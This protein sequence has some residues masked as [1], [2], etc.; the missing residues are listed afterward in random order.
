M[1]PVFWCSVFGLLLSLNGLWSGQ[2]LGPSFFIPLTWNLCM[3]QKN[4]SLHHFIYI[5]SLGSL[6][7][8][9]SL[10]F[11]RPALCHRLVFKTNHNQH[12]IKRGIAERSF[13]GK[14]QNHWIIHLFNIIEILNKY[15]I[16][17]DHRIRKFSNN[18]YLRKVDFSWIVKSIRSPFSK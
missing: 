2:R 7:L 13:C 18:I 17:Q 10:F 14:T 12:F 1:F 6:V 9:S 16:F 4:F 11:S 15:K 8:I 5:L 3:A